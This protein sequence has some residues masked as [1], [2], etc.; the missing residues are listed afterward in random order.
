MDDNKIAILPLIKA[1]IMEHENDLDLLKLA[2][3]GDM[4]AFDALVRI[5]R[6]NLFRIAYNK[7]KTVH[8]SNDAVQEALI[9]A[10]QS[11]DK[12]KIRTNGTVGGWLARIV[13]GKCIDIMRHNY[14]ST[15]PLYFDMWQWGTDWEMGL[16]E[17]FQQMEDRDVED[18]VRHEIA[19]LLRVLP[20][21]RREIAFLFFYLDNS[22]EEIAHK[23]NIT[24]N[25]VY[26]Q[27]SR[28]RKELRK[29]IKKLNNKEI[30]K[31]FLNG[32]V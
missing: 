26:A 9:Y 27:I 10:W 28:A 19:K 25:N 8:E 23:L 29:E 18:Y 31:E 5:H 20:P 1:I 15:T 21:A 6:P 22:R 17:P 24:L 30:F 32:M 3:Q 12:F 7:F 13:V 11:L 16:E 2:Q 4:S 14:A